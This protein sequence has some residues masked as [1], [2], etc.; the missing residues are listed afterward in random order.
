MDSAILQIGA[1]AA[2][3]CAVVWC[4]GVS[5]ARAEEN[6]NVRCETYA[7]RAV[8]Q[9]T[10]M[11]STVGCSNGIDPAAWNDNHDYHFAGCLKFPADASAQAEAYRDDH[12]LKCGALKDASAGAA[13]RHSGADGSA[14]STP[15]AVAR[16]L[17]SPGSVRKG[18]GDYD[19]NLPPIDTTEFPV[20]KWAYSGGPV[21]VLTFRPPREVGVYLGFNAR[22]S[23]I[24]RPVTKKVVI[25]DGNVLHDVPDDSGATVPTDVFAKLDAVAPIRSRLGPRGTTGPYSPH[26]EQDPSF[27]HPWG[28]GGDEHTTWVYTTDATVPIVFGQGGL[29][30][31]LG[32]T[33][34]GSLLQH[35]QE[36]WL[37]DSKAQHLVRLST[38]GIAGIPKELLKGLRNSTLR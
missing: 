11:A 20:F 37:W 3:I 14:T 6:P 5:S 35:N 24:Y 13:F 31:Y 29:M 18:V 12:L 15:A 9:Y 2:V 25:W 36:V 7:R 17:V 21:P 28:V 16:Y 4:A 33:A 32:F 38:S 10:L 23:W 1:S 8:E 34:R 26:P 27:P 22:G 19:P 30:D